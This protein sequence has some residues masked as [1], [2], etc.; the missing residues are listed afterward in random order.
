MNR[1]LSTNESIKINQFSQ[2]LF[3]L[4]EMETWFETYD[5]PNKKDIIYNLLNFVV[6]AHPNYE[7]FESSANFLKKRK[8]PSA[9]K[10]LNK[11]KPYHK[12]GYEICDLP[13][14]ELKIGFEI[15]LLTLAKA[16]NRRK[17]QETPEECNH[18]WHKDL[19]D[20]KYL[21]KLEKNG[22]E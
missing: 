11:N 20:E 10:L 6:Q 9:I 16:D 17:K 2:G 3:T 12:F 7:E 5:L 19:S 4:D 22:L 18:W 14:N 21:E 1:C 8:S 13:E 15:L